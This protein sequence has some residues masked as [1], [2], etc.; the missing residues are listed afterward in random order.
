MTARLGESGQVTPESSK[1]T[2]S[3]SSVTDKQIGTIMFCAHHDQVTQTIEQV[4][5]LWLRQV[6]T[7]LFGG[8]YTTQR[9]GTA[10][11]FA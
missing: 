1:T 5:H 2:D 4:H 9:L 7:V 11:R 10:R 3:P 6:H 8:V